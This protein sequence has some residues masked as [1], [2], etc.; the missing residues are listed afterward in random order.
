ML[1]LKAIAGVQILDQLDGYLDDLCELGARDQFLVCVCILSWASQARAL[2]TPKSSG[3][4]PSSYTRRVR[5][6]PRLECFPR[7]PQINFEAHVHH[8]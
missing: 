1:L 4:I 5:R 7:S 6:S 3:S 8:I 2:A